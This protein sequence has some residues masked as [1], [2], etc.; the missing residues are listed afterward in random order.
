M[1]SLLPIVPTA[2]CPPADDSKLLRMLELVA[3][4]RDAR[5]AELDLS[6][7]DGAEPR[8][9][10]FG[11]PETQASSIVLDCRNPYSATLRLP[12]GQQ[13]ESFIAAATFLLDQVLHAHQ[14]RHQAA[15]LRSAIDA[16]PDAVLVFDLP[17]NILHANSAADQLLSR[18]TEDGLEVLSR[19]GLPRPLVD[20]LCAEVATVA[21]AGES[22]RRDVLPLSDG[23][24]LACTVTRL[25]GSGGV[26][27]VMVRLRKA[28]GPAELAL[29]AFVSEHALSPRE[30]DVVELLHHG[31]STAQIAEQLAISTHTVRDHLKNLYRKTGTSSR[32]ELLGLLARYPGG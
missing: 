20:R 27:G 12:P 21:A 1:E 19:N 4:L 28:G 16:S 18:Q 30:S 14:A 3:A 13:P 31:H 26:L 8:R 24:A 22:E 5:W 15:L 11:T 23:S 2:A 25:S 29:A 10:T 6:V 17:G 32:S 9:F 7:N